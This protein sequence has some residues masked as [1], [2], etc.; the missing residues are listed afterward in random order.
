ME[1]FMWALVV[2]PCLLDLLAHYTHATAD[3]GFGIARCIAA[4][5][6]IRRSLD[7]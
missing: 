1:L 2:G 4:F 3:L 6:A 7:S 5:K